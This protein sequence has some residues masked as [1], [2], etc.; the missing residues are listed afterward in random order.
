[1]FPRVSIT[2]DSELLSSRSKKGSMTGF[3]SIHRKTMQFYLGTR[4]REES[5]SWD[6]TQGTHSKH[7]TATSSVRVPAGNIRHTQFG[8]ICREFNKGTP[9][10][11]IS[12]VQEAT[13]AVQ[14]PGG[15][16]LALGLLHPRLAETT[17]GCSQP[18]ATL[19]KWSS[20][21]TFQ[22]PA[23]SPHRAQQEVRRSPLDAV[24]TGRPPGAQ[25]SGEKVKEWIWRGKEQRTGITGST[26]SI[27]NI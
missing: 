5:I 22:S 12:R 26:E 20:P 11:G 4:S 23:K 17:E 6:L 25:G 27:N 13:G 3:I 7:I 8:I 19:Q 2:F 1:M 18:K 24:H 15:R 14:Y 21:P 10:K 16:L 9:S